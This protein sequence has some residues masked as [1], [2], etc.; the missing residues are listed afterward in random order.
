MVQVGEL[1]IEISVLERATQATKEIRENDV[2]CANTSGNAT[3]PSIHLVGHFSSRLWPAGVRMHTYMQHCRPLQTFRLLG[4]RLRLLA[5]SEGGKGPMHSV[6]DFC[7]HSRSSSLQHFHDAYRISSQRR[8]Q[9][10]QLTAFLLNCSKEQ[11]RN[12]FTNALVLHV[13]RPYEREKKREA[14]AALFP[15]RTFYGCEKQ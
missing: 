3:S 13:Y 10:P 9:I 8:C 2:V 11:T 15:C 6:T 4:S 7:W 12:T 5:K 1:K 14:E